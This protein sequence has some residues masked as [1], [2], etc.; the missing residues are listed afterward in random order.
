MEVLTRFVWR[1]KEH[2]EQPEY[3]TRALPLW[4]P[5]SQFLTK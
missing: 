5:T 2:H 1:D 3:E 4:Q